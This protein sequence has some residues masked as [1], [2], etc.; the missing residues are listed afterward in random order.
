MPELTLE[1]KVDKML[2]QNKIIINK[3][4]KL[5]PSKEVK[6]DQKLVNKQKLKIA[7]S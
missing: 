1:E 6:I 3:L 5:M 4:E 7:Q 2:A